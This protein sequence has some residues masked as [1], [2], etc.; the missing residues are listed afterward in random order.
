MRVKLVGQAPVEVCIYLA[1]RAER[2]SGIE[3]P[4]DLLNGGDEF[5]PST[6]FEERILIFRRSAVLVLTVNAKHEG[7]LGE[8]PAGEGDRVVQVVRLWLEDGTSVTGELTYWRPEGQRR[9]QDFLNTAEP[10]IALRD[11]DVVHLVNRH[12]ISSVSEY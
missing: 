6:D 9:V 1:E 11:G 10:F 12:R 4:S 7:E 3:C 2:H 5:I 8:G